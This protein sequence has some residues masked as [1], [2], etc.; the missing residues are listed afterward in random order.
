MIT[1]TYHSLMNQIMHAIFRFL[2]FFSWL[3]LL[4]WWNLSFMLFNYV[5]SFASLNN[6]KSHFYLKKYYWTHNNNT[7]F[8]GSISDE[9]LTQVIPEIVRV[10]PDATNS[11]SE[12]SGNLQSVSNSVDTAAFSNHIILTI[13]ALFCISFR[14]TV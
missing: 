12:T 5:F 2:R 10:I 7:N 1:G 3:T 13:I 9:E 4:W 8:T 11:S 14:R 6:P